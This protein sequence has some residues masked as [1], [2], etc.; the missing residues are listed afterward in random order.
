VEKA[1]EK[2]VENKWLKKHGC[3]KAFV[4]ECVEN[5]G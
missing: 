1:V 2:A 5:R 3:G 4:R